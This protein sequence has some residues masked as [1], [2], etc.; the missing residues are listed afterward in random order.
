M[1]K[2]SKIKKKKER[3]EKL[4]SKNPQNNAPTPRDVRR[5]VAAPGL[6]PQRRRRRISRK[7]LITLAIWVAALV[8]AIYFLTR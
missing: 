8:V 2:K 5:A 6:L 4:S 3:L 7:F 1:S